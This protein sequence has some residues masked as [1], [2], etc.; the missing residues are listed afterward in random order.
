MNIE[1]MKNNLYESKLR[2]Y[3]RYKEKQ[4]ALRNNLSLVRFSNRC[5]NHINCFRFSLNESKAHILKKLEICIDLLRNNHK[6]ITEAIFDNG[7]R[8]DVFDLSEGV[9]YEILNTETDEMFEEK[10]KKYPEE[11]EVVKVRI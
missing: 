6:F 9:V 3:R 11:V 4:Y 8:C 2:C 1:L 5:G 10:I 7:S